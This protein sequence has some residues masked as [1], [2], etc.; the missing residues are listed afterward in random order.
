MNGYDFSS[1]LIET[2]PC[3]KMY[4]LYGNYCGGVCSDE[5]R[6][7]FLD[8]L[9]Y[10]EIFFLKTYNPTTRWNLAGFLFNKIAYIYVVCTYKTTTL[11]NISELAKN[12]V[13]QS[14]Q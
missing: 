10:F 12:V 13:F 7:Q 11:K 4:A 9:K 1:C 3:S 5:K 14:V 2:K 6:E 8:N